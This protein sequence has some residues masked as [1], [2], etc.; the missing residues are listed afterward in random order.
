MIGAAH[1]HWAAVVPVGGVALLLLAWYWRRL[2]R[3]EVLSSRRRIRRASLV[4]MAAVVVL[5]VRGLIFVDPAVD[6]RAYAIIWT[7]VVV[8]VGL[9]VLTAVADAINSFRAHQI[10]REAALSETAATVLAALE[11]EAARRRAEGGAPEP[12]TSRDENG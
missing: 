8:G 2:G 7:L 6:G 12:P 1:L 9:V 5:A 11:K 3:P 4:I 10:D